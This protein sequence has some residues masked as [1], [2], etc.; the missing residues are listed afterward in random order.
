MDAEHT[1][2][3]QAVVDRVTSYQESATE[4]TVEDALREALAQTD[5]DLDDQ[6]VGALV[7]AIEKTDEPV[8]VAT[9]LA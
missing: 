7:Q 2:A 1:A 9:V 8:D 6:Q 5:V 4:G 3:V